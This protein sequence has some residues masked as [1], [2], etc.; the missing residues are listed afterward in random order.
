MTW[1]NRA[2]IAIAAALIVF[3]IGRYVLKSWIFAAAGAGVVIVVLAV[4]FGRPRRQ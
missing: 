4:Y 3:V 2:L 1:I